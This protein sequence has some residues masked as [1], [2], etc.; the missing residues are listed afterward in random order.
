MATQ[1]LESV[2]SL[3]VAVEE[4]LGAYP[5]LQ[6]IERIVIKQCQRITR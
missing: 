3:K 5:A 1:L 6:R 4:R 2:V